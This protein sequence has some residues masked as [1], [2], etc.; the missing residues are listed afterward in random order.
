MMNLKQ[1]ALGGFVLAV[2]V[3]IVAANF[4]YQSTTDA[5]SD[6]GNDAWATHRMELVAWNNV[7]WTAWVHDGQFELVPADDGR[8]HRHSSASVAFVDWDG[9]LWQAKI[10]GSEFLLAPNGEWEGEIERSDSIRY[11]D[12]SGNRQLRT[13]ANLER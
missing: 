8:W 7:R 5:A 4:A 12:W 6:P 1:R 10:D 3:A 2:L 9:E 13:V 11:R